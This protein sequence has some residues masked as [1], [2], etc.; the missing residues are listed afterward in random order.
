MTATRETVVSIHL[1]ADRGG[2]MT[3]VPTVH[4]M[5]GR[6]LDGDR[7]CGRGGEGRAVTLIE[8]E[9]FEALERDYKFTLQPG[10]ARRNI[11]TR[12]VALN[13]LVGREFTVGSVKLRGIELCEPCGHLAKMT[14]DIVSRGLV[15]RGGLRCDIL[16]EG[17]IRVGDTIRI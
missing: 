16:T 7:H 3:T 8:S 17:E 11:V 10:D 14:S 6:G 4:A 2:K 12:G 13:H 9:A 1:I 5:P 15:H